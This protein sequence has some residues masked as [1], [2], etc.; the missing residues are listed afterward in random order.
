MK[1]L[2][3]DYDSIIEIHDV[4]LNVSG[5]KPGIL[6]D[7]VIR[8]AVHRP[9]TYQQYYSDYNLHIVCAVLLDALARNHAFYEGNKR[10]AL[11]AM[12]FTYRINGVKLNYNMSL[13]KEYED[14]V[15]W[16][17]LEKPEIDEIVDRLKRLISKHQLGALQSGIKKLF[18]I[19]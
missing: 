19:E 13:N 7:D 15:L 8:S 6:H 3:P 9:I 2:L 14:L 1:I 12:I 18:H 10:T 16:V 11:M 4:V 5:G 17:V